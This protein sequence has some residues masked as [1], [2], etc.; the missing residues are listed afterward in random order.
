MKLIAASVA[1]IFSLVLFTPAHSQE[2]GAY[3]ENTRV[4][5][6]AKHKVKTISLPGRVKLEYVEKGNA[7]GIPVIFLHGIT[8]SWHSFE[9]V[10]QYLP[11]NIHA[12]AISQRG[13]GDS[14]RPADGFLPKDFADDVAAFIREKKLGPVIIAGHSM[15]GF[16]AQQFAIL[17][18]K[19]TKGLVI[20]DSDAGFR[21]N[22]GMN[23]FY[24]EVMKM[25]G[26]IDR[27]YMDGFQKATLAIPINPDYYETLVSEG[28][29]CPV[30]VFQGA[31]TGIMET[32]LVKDLKKVSAPT[33]IFWGDKDAFCLRAGQDVMKKNIK[34]SRLI[35]YEGTGHALHWEQPQRFVKDLTAFIAKMK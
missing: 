28:M 18:P 19:L 4:S 7:K 34:N 3:N 24:Q 1:T 31:L 5:S 26:S 29:K 35:I 16:N 6:P 15:G 23:E 11:A 27:E 14:E 17:Y 33:L 32:D 20:I 21:D 25:K 30:R 9:S 22:P 13:H 2:A 8:D 12:F 10:L